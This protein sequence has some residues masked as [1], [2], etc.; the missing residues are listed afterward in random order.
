MNKNN[1]KRLL[2]PLVVVVL[3]Q[4]G[5]CP[6]PYLDD[7]PPN[8][9]NSD[10]PVYLS[11]TDLRNSIAVLPARTLDSIGRIYLYN[12]YFFLNEKNIGIH[13]F[14]NSDPFNPRNAGFIYIP[15]N[16]EVSI[17]DSY[18]YADSYID[19]VTLDLN[20]LADIQ[21][22]DREEGVFPWD[23]HQNVPDDTNFSFDD[24][25]ESLGVVVGYE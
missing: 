1:R 15:G 6:F 8:N 20:N 14:D 13:I 23:A 22:V 25:D 17:R 11:Y 7:D 3:L 4:L 10:Q 18:L 24:L 19:L 12:N 21:V 16:T 5:G 9:D 2:I